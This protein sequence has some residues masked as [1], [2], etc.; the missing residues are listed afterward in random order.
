MQE[1]LNLPA[2][3]H[4]AVWYYKALL[5]EVRPMHRHRELELNIVTAGRASYLLGD[6]RYELGADDLVWLFPAQ[7]HQLID[8]SPDYEMWIV[9]FSPAGLQGAVRGTGAA[10]LAEKLPVGRFCKS[11]AR[12]D[13]LALGRLCAELQGAEKSP[14]LVNAGLRYLLL[15]G[16]EKF[17]AASDEPTYHALHPA[18][19]NALSL[20][21]RGE[22]E[23][24]LLELSRHAR[25]S[26][27]R[28]S[29]AFKQQV[30]LGIAEYRNRMRLE[31]FLE[32]Y[33]KE[34]RI[35][36]LAAAFEAGFNSY[37][38]FYRVFCR[39]MGQS[40]ADYRRRTGIKR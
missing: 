31:R 20:L 23:E 29:R 12:A 35:T 28:L 5:S 17:T 8:R 15:R 37:A 7:E 11:L 32:S 33:G 24:S 21:R 25:L 38:Q 2:G 3:T 4:G 40:P 27:A 13:A 18:V 39:L 34:R 19:E 14:S 30:G 1:K 22:S 9:V 6:R 10:V 36:T 16:W 26:A